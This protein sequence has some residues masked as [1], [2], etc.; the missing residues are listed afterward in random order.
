MK[1]GFEGGLERL[2]TKL[3]QKTN[4]PRRLT[5]QKP[6][7]ILSGENC[8][9]GRRVS[10]LNGKD[11]FCFYFLLNSDIFNANYIFLINV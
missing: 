11:V 5:F 7:A 10:F 8:S 9:V 4:P 2:S 1:I 6:N 3:Y